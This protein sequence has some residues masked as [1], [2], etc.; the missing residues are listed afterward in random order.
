[1]E[2]D[3]ANEEEVNIS[4]EDSEVVELATLTKYIFDPAFTN[5]FISAAANGEEQ[6]ARIGYYP[7]EKTIDLAEFADGGY[8]F[9]NDNHSKYASELEE[10]L[11]EVVDADKVQKYLS[12]F[13]KFWIDGRQ[14][15]QDSPEIMEIKASI[16]D[17]DRH[18]YGNRHTFVNKA[19]SIPQS[20]NALFSPDEMY[21]IFEI[22]SRLADKCVEDYLQSRSDWEFT[23]LNRIYLHRGIFPA[24]RIED[25]VLVEENYLS[26][27][28]MAVTVP[29]VFAQTFDSRSVHTGEPAML[30]APFPLFHGRIVMFAPFIRGM[31][32]GQL[33]VCVA[34][35]LEFCPLR[36]QGMFPSGV[37]GLSFHEYEFNELPPG[38]VWTGPLPD[39][40][41]RAGSS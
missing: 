14:M 17:H 2:M 34:P 41:L 35:P 7:N 3:R 22:I 1:M 18:Y 5:R 28:S 6:I 23:S 30:G 8:K 33:E 13:R 24:K 29:E 25:A 19:N 12:A 20:V 32:L 31:T 36:Y 39:R 16:R 10:R 4:P 21:H 27:Y 15:R 11:V 40:I 37:P 38:A 9:F 26:S